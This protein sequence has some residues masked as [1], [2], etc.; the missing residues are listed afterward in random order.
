MRFPRGR[1][2]IWIVVAII[3]TLGG[4]VLVLNLLPGEKQ[5]EQRIPRL[6]SVNEP[7]YQRSMGVLLGP[8]IL[9]GNRVDTLLNGAQIFPAMLGEIEKA[10]QTITFETYIYW[11]GAIGE[12]FAEK[13]AERSRAGVKIHVLLDWVG[14]QRM[15]PELLDRLT[16]AG[17]E[18]ERYHPLS[19]YHVA[20]LNNRTHRKL[21]VVD[22]RVGFTGG[23]GIADK[24]DGNAQDADH[25]RDTHFRVEGPVVAQMQATFL[26]NWMK[27]RGEVL[28]GD[29]YFPPLTPHGS[30]PAQM[31]SSSPSGGSESMHLMYLLAITAARQS[32]DLSSAYFVPDEMTIQSLIDAAQRGVRIRVI[33]PGTHTDSE[34]VRRASRAT[35]GPMLKAG[36]KIF[37]YQPTM[38]HVKMMVVD[39]L[40]ASFGSTNFDE[41][42]F[43]LNDEA[44][45]NVYAADFSARQLADFERDLANTREITYAQWLD[46]PLSE[47]AWENLAAL[48]RTQL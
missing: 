23:V 44:N 9:Q 26:D 17:V 36:V 19:W 29:A 12:Q 21:L 35:W 40:V 3:A 47:K 22:G 10:R 13:L 27:V 43:R 8:A 5:V 37:E 31:F 34:T 32:I 46:R 11:E 25:W 30:Q 7:A 24:W 39:G 28:H 6:Y 48:L 38:F 15:K 4:I 18:I 45:L 16:A 2:I 41:R 20:R 33:V 1:F 42:S 14:S